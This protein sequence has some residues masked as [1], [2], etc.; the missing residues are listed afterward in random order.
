MSGKGRWIEH[1]YFRTYRIATRVEDICL[2]PLSYLRELEALFLEDGILAFASSWQKDTALHRII[3]YVADDFFAGDT[4]GP[5]RVPWGSDHVH[6][7]WILSVDLALHLYGLAEE[8]EFFVP[9]EHEIVRGEDGIL[10]QHTPVWVKDACYEHYQDVMLTQA[11]EDLL[12]RI[13]EEVFFVMFLNRRALE[14][15]NSHLAGRL[16]EIDPAC[17]AE[18]G[19]ESALLFS[20]VGE[21]K[22]VRP[23][24]WAKRAVFYRERGR[25]ASCRTD[26]SGLVDTFPDANYDHMAP[27]AKG[28][29]ND[30]TNLQL[31]CG[32]CNLRK[33][34][35]SVVS[36]N[37]YRRWY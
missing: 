3:R 2:D 8:P 21:L 37:R 4:S 27:L 16:Q 15:L 23:P 7:R 9:E 34:D 1:E 29:L 17:L 19:E 36:S 33:S 35:K 18:D 11:Y 28:G 24:V 14:G 30:L 10:R 26:L 12:M 20:G 6:P 13:A 25:C 31:L 22:R 32:R 5:V